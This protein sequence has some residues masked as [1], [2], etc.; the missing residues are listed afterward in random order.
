MIWESYSNI[1]QMEKLGD[2]WGWVGGGRV[3]LGWWW[4]WVGD[5]FL[6]IIRI[7]RANQYWR[8][9]IRNVEHK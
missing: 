5:Q 3:G 4:G 8:V 9:K 1:W 2:G 6:L 7:G